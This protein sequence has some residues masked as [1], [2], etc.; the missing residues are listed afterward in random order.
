M[1]NIDDFRDFDAFK[2]CRS[3][4][5]ELGFLVRTTPLR[6][7]RNLADQME[8]AAIS[9]LSNFAEGAERDGNAEFIQFLTISKGSIGELRAQLIYALDTELIDQDR[10][11]SLDGMAVSASR[12]IGGLI[13]Y[14]KTSGRPGRKFEGRTRPIPKRKQSRTKRGKARKS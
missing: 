14:L 9:I 7:N 10:Y 8:R 12:L 4:T 11:H 13:R 2:A 1:P 3:F 5:R 6:R